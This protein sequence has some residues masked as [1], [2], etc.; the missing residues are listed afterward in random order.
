[1]R[2]K[3]RD[4]AILRHTRCFSIEIRR[5]RAQI[6][7]A[8]LPSI[9]LCSSACLRRCRLRGFRLRVFGFS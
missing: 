3:S 6:L 4:T 9:N 2:R 8:S 5:K 7:S 1:M